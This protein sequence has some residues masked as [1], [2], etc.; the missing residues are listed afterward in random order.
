MFIAYR[1]VGFGGVGTV[2]EQREDLEGSRGVLGFWCGC[3]ML[4]G[5][6]I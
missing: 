6:I 3:G 2:G 5:N 1:L 4:K